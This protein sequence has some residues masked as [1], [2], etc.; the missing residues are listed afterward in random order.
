MTAC[1]ECGFEYDLALATSV[2]ILARGHAREYAD[3][4]QAAPPVLRQRS[5]PHVWSP[6]EYACHMRDVLLVQRERV[7]A[8]R[9]LDTPVAESM[10]RDERV[11]HDGYAQQTPT[12]V[13]RQLQDAASLF[14]DVLDRLSP[15]DWDRTLVYSYPEPT[16]RSLRW[17]AVHTLHELR[18]H[19]L[20]MRRQLERRD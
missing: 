16:E 8:A 18:H 3:L 14:H 1:T 20:D 13:A 12:D 2:P 5:S 6:L 7:L 19:L 4:L 11:E 9:R 10:G 15:S 17:V